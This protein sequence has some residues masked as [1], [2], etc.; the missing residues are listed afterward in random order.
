MKKVYMQIVLLS[1][2]FGGC[3][4]YNNV[5]SQ[6]PSFSGTIV[7]KASW[8]QDES[9][10]V[11]D[12]NVTFI[13][14]NSS[15]CAPY[16]DPL[17]PLRA[18]TLTDIDHDTNPF[19]GYKPSLSVS[20]F[21]ANFISANEM[22]NAVL[23][24]K[25]KSTRDAIQKSYKVKLNS[26]TILYEKQRRLQYNKQMYD[27]TRIRNK[28]SFDLFEGIPNF[29]SL[30][31]E[32]VHLGINGVDKGLFTK[33]ESYDKQYLLN[34]DWNKDDNLY[35]AQEFTFEMKPALAL[36]SKGKPVDVDAFNAVIEPERGKE[37]SKLIEMLNAVNNEKVSSDTV[38]SKYFNRENYLTW[39]AINILTGN[40]DTT[41]QNFF[42]L[43]PL[44]SDTFYFLPWDYDGAWGWYKQDSTRIFPYSRLEKSISRW[45]DSPLH[46]KFLSV[47][48]NRDDLDKKIYFLRANYFSDAQIQKKVDEY[49]PIVEPYIFAQPDKE[50]L[51][52]T[53]TN[54][55]INIQNWSAECDRLKTR[56]QENID[57][58]EA[59]K[60]SPMPFWQT[61][62]YDNGLLRL[63]WSASIDLEGDAIVYD[64]KVSKSPDFNTTIINKIGL[65]P[66][67]D[68]EAKDGEMVYTETKTLTAGIYYMQV[69]A[70]ES[71][72]SAHY[73]Y[74]F[75]SYYD[76]PT[77]KTYHG[78][79]EFEVK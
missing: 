72:N 48:K 2:L 73:R 15:L 44:H 63:S 16:T 50:N 34:R 1:F 74:G 7:D 6:E 45:W 53:D 60:G 43:N 66:T 3:E 9:K 35:K 79:L 75:E 57:E 61:E 77:N 28:L 33:V 12:A 25:G 26:K 51:M 55:S 40:F 24:Q 4:S 36:T 20:F 11:K 54:N 21:T 8:Y 65:I 42:L 49:K 18:C 68:L 69:K 46:K 39:L 27:A 5:S 29:A 17:A 23:V 47:K 13:T 19:D 78:V 38:I 10:T 14:P 30:K 41:T 70:R 76:A 67:I 56:L 22:P 32:F 62:N 52:Y 37:Q 64:L 59:Q 31:T 58:Y 71:A